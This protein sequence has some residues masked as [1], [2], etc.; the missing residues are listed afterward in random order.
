M[1][2]RVKIDD[3]SVTVFA[4]PL[5]QV[6]TEDGP[7]AACD[8]FVGVTVNGVEFV[9]PMSFRGKYE[10]RV[11]LANRV[12]ATGNIDPDCW[13]RMAPS[14]SLEDKFALYAEREDEVRHGLRSEADMYHGID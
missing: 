3:G 10:A 2:Q 12:K 13:T 6:S 4:G 14:P 1:A 8:Y 9:H 5:Y 7:S 11:R